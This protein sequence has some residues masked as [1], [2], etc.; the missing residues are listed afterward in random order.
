[1]RPLS[2]VSRAPRRELGLEG[3]EIEEV[4]RAVAVEV[5][6][7][8][9]GGEEVL[10]GEE[11]EEC[12]FAIAIEIDAAEEAAQVEDVGS[13]GP[14]G[15]ADGF[16]GGADDDAGAV[17]VDAPAEAAAGRLGQQL[18]RLSP[19]AVGP[20]LEGVGSPGAATSDQLKRSAG[21]HHVAVHGN[22]GAETVILHWI[23]VLERRAETP[24][25]A[26]QFVHV[27]GALRCKSPVGTWAANRDQSPINRHRPPELRTFLWL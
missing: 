9:A 1:T 16:A 18:C 14:D 7:G 2:G 24:L 21:D 27:D 17:G 6:G 22:G 11:V 20:S 5:G 10:E 3:E 13:A 12:E 23:V 8:V 4:Q 25:S 15:S 19:G 26:G